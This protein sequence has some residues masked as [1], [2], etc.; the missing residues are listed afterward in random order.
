MFS[1]LVTPALALL[2]T[3]ALAL[4][5]VGD[6]SVATLSESQLVSIAP[7]SSSCASASF[8]SECRTATQAVEPISASFAT[9]NVTTPGEQAAIISTIAFESDGFQYQINHFAGTPGQG[10]RNMQSPEYNLKYAQ[11]I[12]A[13]AP[14]LKEIQTS[15]VAAVLNLL[16][17]YTNYDFGSAAWFLSSQCSDSVRSGLQSGSA[18][19]FSAY[20]TCIGTTETSDRDAYHQR[21][22]TALGVTTS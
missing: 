13:L 4:P 1:H 17:K 7:K 16:I 8:P 5:A 3:T 21:A 14:Y 15:N 2:I 9:Y 20:I 19:G 11:S 18:A 6:S 10:T 22:V 12:P